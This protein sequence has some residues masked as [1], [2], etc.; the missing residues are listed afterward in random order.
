MNNSCFLKTDWICDARARE[1]NTI[2]FG[3]RKMNWLFVLLLCSSTFMCAA[4]CA[5][6][7]ELE[8]DEHSKHK[9]VFSLCEET[10][11]FFKIQKHSMWSKVKTIG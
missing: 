6:V 1:T 8:H 5:I 3:A 4:V 10:H 9:S 11:F 7:K 2:F